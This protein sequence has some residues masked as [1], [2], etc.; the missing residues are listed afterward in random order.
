MEATPRRG[1][2]AFSIEKDGND[3][4]IKILPPLLEGQ[5]LYALHNILNNN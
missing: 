4:S 1:P 5:R 3:R 2:F